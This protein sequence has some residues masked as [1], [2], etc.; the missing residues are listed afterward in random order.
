MTYRNWQKRRPGELPDNCYK[1]KCDSCGKEWV[2]G[3]QTNKWPTYT[4]PDC[5]RG[6]QNKRSA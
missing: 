6:H 5:N 3:I 2:V 1:R 4:C